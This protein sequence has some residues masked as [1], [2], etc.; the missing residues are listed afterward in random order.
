MTKQVKLVPLSKR[1]LQ[2]VKMIASGLNSREIALKLGLS[3]R[4]VEVHRYNILRKTNS[5]NSITAIQKVLAKKG[6]KV[7]G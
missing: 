7:L 4:T 5:K 2:I 3:N 1:Q 6:S